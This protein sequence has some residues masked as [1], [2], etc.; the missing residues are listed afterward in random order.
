M[1]TDDTKNRKLANTA[2]ATLFM[3][4]GGLI[5]TYGERGL[6]Q[7]KSWL[8]AQADEAKRRARTHE[9]EIHDDQVQMVLIVEASGAGLKFHHVQAGRLIDEE[10]GL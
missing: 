7:I 3:V 1:K 4:A 5:D 2:I 6:Q 8:A 9:A 10:A